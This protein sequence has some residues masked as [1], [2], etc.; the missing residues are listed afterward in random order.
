MLWLVPEGTMPS[1]WWFYRKDWEG[2]W[3]MG[4]RFALN[5][6]QFG[7]FGPE[8]KSTELNARC[9]HTK[10]K[11]SDEQENKTLFHHGILADF[12]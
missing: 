5:L 4:L 9:L 8:A 12:Q 3:G 2:E 10:A 7:S 6:V 11:G 1:K